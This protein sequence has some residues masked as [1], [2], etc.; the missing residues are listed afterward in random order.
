M[1]CLG[2]APVPT[3]VSAQTSWAPGPHMLLPAERLHP[4]FT[5]SKTNIQVLIVITGS[6]SLPKWGARSSPRPLFLTHPQSVLLPSLSL[7]SLAPAPFFWLDDCN[8]TITYL[9][10]TN[11]ASFP[12]V[13]SHYYQSD[14]WKSRQIL[15]NP[16]KN[17]LMIPPCLQDKSTP[18]CK[19]PHDVGPA[20]AFSSHLSPAHPEPCPS[21]TWNCFMSPTGSD[22]HAVQYSLP[23]IFFPWHPGSV[24]L[25][26]KGDS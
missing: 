12:Q 19:V 15:K 24:W 6:A 4:K 11:L 20:P 10:D 21:S 7:G 16:A 3:S 1:E 5:T 13:S 26:R 9:P 2:A 23:R 25:K 17:P 22:F 14:F 18:F 8:G